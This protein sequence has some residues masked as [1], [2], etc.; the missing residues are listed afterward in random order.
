MRWQVVILCAP[1]TAPRTNTP[2]TAAAALGRDPDTQPGTPV[3]DVAWTP[4]TTPRFSFFGH[5]LSTFGHASG[6]CPTPSRPA[7]LS[8]K[9]IKP[10]PVQYSCQPNFPPNPTS[11]R[12]TLVRC[13]HTL[14]HVRSIPE[15]TLGEG[16]APCCRHGDGPT[17]AHEKKSQNLHTIDMATAVR[18]RNVPETDVAFSTISSAILLLVRPSPPAGQEALFSDTHFVVFSPG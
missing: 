7:R 6:T 10:K 4:D 5:E 13:A 14:P 11:L 1:P 2:C 16:L 12:G 3:F 8:E 15:A 17:D 18:I 9:S